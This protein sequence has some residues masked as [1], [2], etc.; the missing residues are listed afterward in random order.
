MT[1]TSV[2]TAN[3]PSESPYLPRV[4]KIVAAEM[5]TDTEKW[6][7]IVLDD[8]EPFAYN[9][10]Q[11]VQCSIMG[12][13]EAPISICSSPTEGNRFEMCVRNVGRLTN[14]MHQLDVGDTLGVRGPFGNGFDVRVGKGED[15]LFVAG[16]L[17]LAPMRGFIKY[18]IDN[19]QDYGKITILVGAKSPDLLLFKHD[20]EEWQA[21][22]DVDCLVTVDKGDDSWSGRV[23]LITTLFPEVSID[24]DRTTAV[25]VGPPIMFKFAVLEALAKGLHGHDILCSLERRMK[26]GLGK[27]GHCQ[28]RHVYVCKEGP[29]FTYNQ[30]HQLRE[31]I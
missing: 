28:I 11:F 5:F 10:G 27:C 18:T 17:G 3:A 7:R 4:G 21:R 29:V 12:I 6:Y 8:G 26:C 19:R 2:T 20:L 16:G 15:M 25:I 9:P 23:G 24:P 13:G 14:A 31:G 30:V 22:P 1:D